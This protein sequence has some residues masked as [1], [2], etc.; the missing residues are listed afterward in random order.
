MLGMG[1]FYSVRIVFN[2]SCYKIY[3]YYKLEYILHKCILPNMK[4]ASGYS[5]V[6]VNRGDTD[7]IS[8]RR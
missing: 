7:R 6:G 4:T 5:T 8:K 3:V 2:K 1:E